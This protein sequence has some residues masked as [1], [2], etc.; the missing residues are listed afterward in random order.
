MQP[1][2]IP[3]QEKESITPLE[4]I[5]KSTDFMEISAFFIRR[6]SVPCTEVL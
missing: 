2:N 5:K 4:L 1:L 3:S 6:I